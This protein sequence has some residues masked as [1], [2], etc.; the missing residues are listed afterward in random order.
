MTQ[1]ETEETLT[2][3][4]AGAQRK[5]FYV[6]GWEIEDYLRN[7][8][9]NYGWECIPIWRIKG[10]Y[11]SNRLMHWLYTIY[12]DWKLVHKYLVMQPLEFTEL[13][14]EKGRIPMI[15][16]NDIAAWF[17]SQL[18]FENRGLYTNIKRCW[19]LMRTKLNIFM[20]TLP[21]KD[22]FPG[23][24]LRDLTAEVF[25]SPSSCYDFNRWSWSMNF[26][27]P[28]KVKKRAISVCEDEVFDIYQVPKH[29]FIEIYWKRRME[30]AEGAASDLVFLKSLSRTPPNSPR[31]RRSSREAR[32]PRLRGLWLM[33]DGISHSDAYMRM[34]Y[35][36]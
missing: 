1:Q 21:R 5:G 23:F 20:A 18:Y 27:D 26:R 15:G 35:F 28:R 10:S 3:F 16:W 36:N 30:L 2:F 13:L 24:I 9:Q 34:I 29:E 14:K 31:R 6:S 19:T 33:L 17:D 4:M 22:E 25:C 32:G 7:A 12:G 8:I 11:K